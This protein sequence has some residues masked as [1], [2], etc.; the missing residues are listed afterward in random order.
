MR[1]QIL[2]P[3]PRGRSVSN[4]SPPSPTRSGIGWGKAAF[5]QLLGLNPQLNNVS[6][7]SERAGYGYTSADWL[8]SVSGVK[9]GTINL[10]NEGNALTVSQ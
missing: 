6:T 8:D 5:Y 9:D 3:T 2:S 4:W 10:D 1:Q 7:P